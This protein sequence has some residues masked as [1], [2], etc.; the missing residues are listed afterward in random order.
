[1][2][3]ALTVFGSTMRPT[4]FGQFLSSLFLTLTLLIWFELWG[5]FP[6]K[7]GGWRLDWFENISFPDECYFLLEADCR[8][9][10]K[11][12]RKII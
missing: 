2:F 3:T 7:G 5:R 8:Q 9:E 10:V 11:A 12:A 6:S 4:E 1:V